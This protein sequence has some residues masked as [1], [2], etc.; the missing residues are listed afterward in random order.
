VPNT[1]YINPLVAA[2][3]GNILKQPFFVHIHA[4]HYGYLSPVSASEP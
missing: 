2:K 3:L 1:V 4:E